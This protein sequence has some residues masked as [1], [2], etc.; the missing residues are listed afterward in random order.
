MANNQIKIGV[1]FQIDKTGLNELQNSLK[2]I[3][4]TASN[5]TSNDK[6]T[7][8]LREAASAAKVVDTALE[9]AFNKN[10]G[11]TN[12]S[13]FN[14][15]LKK[16]NLTIDQVRIKFAE[17]GQAG[18]KAWN[19]L[20]SQIL[21]TNTQLKQSNKLLDE[22]ATSM[23]NTV[24][25]G[26]TSSIF[27]TIT[28][29]ISKAYTYTK[30]LD[31][32]LN[33]IRIVTDK[34]AESMEKFA[35]QANEAA[36]GLGAS[37]LDYTEA[38]LIYY[39]QGLDDAQVAARAETTLKAANVT[40]QY[41]EEVSEQLTAVWNGYKVSAEEA[42]LYVDKLAAVAA[43]TAADLEELSTGMS[44]VASAANS[45]G[46]DIDQLNAQLATI[47]S[48]TRQ[49]PESVGTALKT[50]YARMSDLKVGGTDE[51]G[52]GLGD[53]SG[54]MESMGIQVL[55]ASGN[56][57]EMGDV[58]EEVAAK[59]DTWT[60]A[61]KT[62]MAQVMAGKRQYNNLVALFD[63]WDMYTDSLNES[64]NAAGTLQKQQ[65]IYLE[66]T[67]AKL[68]Q[69]RTTAESVY[70]GLIKTDELNTGIE[71]LTDF[72]QVASN[73]VNSFGGGIKSISSL[74]L[75]VANIFNKQ[76]ANGI[77]NVI[78]GHK[79]AVDNAEMYRIKAEQLQKI[80]KNVVNIDTMEGVKS[81]AIAEGYQKQAEYAQK[82]QDIQ[83]NLS[84]EEY[85]R[86]NTLTAEV[87]ELTEQ[88]TLL[89]KASVYAADQA[90]LNISDDKMKAVFEGKANF[91]EE[92]TKRN[93]EIEDYTNQ[94]NQ[95]KN[96]EKIYN[97]IVEKKQI[98]TKEDIKN[99]NLIEQEK[100][101]IEVILK[102]NNKKEV[103]MKQ[104]AKVLKGILQSNKQEIEDHE[105]II[106]R[107]KTE[108]DIYKKIEQ[109]AASAQR[110]EAEKG[111]KES[112]LNEGLG[113]G[114]QSANVLKGVTQV[115][116]ALSTMA[117]SW[118]S[119]NSLMDTWED[120][121]LSVG[122]KLSQTLMTVGMTLP[123]LISS[124]KSLSEVMGVQTTLMEVI[125]ALHMKSNVLKTTGLVLNKQ[126]LASLTAEVVIT[127][128]AAFA[129]ALKN[130]NDRAAVK[131]LT[132][133]S[134]AILS[135]IGLT[136]QEKIAVMQAKVA[137]DAWNS[138]LLANP[139][140]KVIAALAGLVAIIG[141]VISANE[142]HIE[143]QNELAKQSI[144]EQNKIQSEI[145]ANTELYNSY[146]KTF[147]AYKQ[148]KATK[149]E[150]KTVTDQLCEK[151]NLERAI[152]ANLTGDYQ[153]LT[154]EIIKTQKVKIQEGLKSA[155]NEKANAESLVKGQIG[156]DKRVQMSAGIQITGADVQARKIMEK[157]YTDNYG[158]GFN[159]NDI[160]SVVIA[161]DAL[162]NAMTEI[163]NEMDVAQRNDSDII[164]DAQ[165][166]LDSMTESVEAYKTA[167]QDVQTYSAQLKSL[168]IDFYN[169]DNLEEY[170]EKRKQLIE[171]M[172]AD[173]SFEGKS[174][175]ELEAM[176]DTFISQQNDSLGLYS[177]QTKQ[178]A[179]MVEQYGSAYENEIT[180]WIQSLPEEQLGI[181][182]SLEL[183]ELDYEEVQT[184][185]QE[186]YAIGE[187]NTIQVKIDT[188]T[189]LQDKINKGE[190]LTEEERTAAE[191]KLGDLINWEEFDASTSLEQINLLGEALNELNKQRIDN[192]NN[193]KEAED[194]NKKNEEERI[195][196]IN[197]IT[198]DLE[199]LDKTTPT[200]SN[201]KHEIE[202]TKKELLNELKELENL[203]YSIDLD[204]NFDNTVLDIIGDKV[205]NIVSK[206]DQLKN[207]S[208]L[209]GEGF[210]VAAKD[211]ETL[212][213]QFPALMQNADVL[214]NG[215]VKLQEEIVKT[216]LNG[217]AA[218]LE[219][220]KNITDQQLE[221]QIVLL[222]AEIESNNSKIKLMT[223]YLTGKIESNKLEEGLEKEQA[224]LESK[225]INALGEEEYKSTIQAA[226]NNTE[227]TNN[228]LGNLDKIGTRA[229]AVGEAI[230]AA[231]AGE[232][233]NYT[234]GG[235]TAVTTTLTAFQSQN[236]VE[237]TTRTAKNDK[238]SAYIQEVE[239]QREEL[240]K[241]NEEKEKLIASY[242]NLQSELRSGVT[243]A[244][245][246]MKGAAS[247]TGGKANAD[248]KEQKKAQDEI[249]RYWELNKAIEEVEESLSDLD[250]KQEKLYGKELIASLKQENQ[251]LAQQADRYQALAA[252][253]RQEA[254]E[255][256]GLLSSYGVVFDAQGGI[257]NYLAAT[258]AALEAY[259]QTVAAYN[260]MLIDEA[261]FKA[262]ERAYENFKSTLARYET[263]YYQE[264]VD[265]QNKL[266]EIHRQELE[267]NL[268]AWEVEIQLKLDMNELE[269]Q[270]DDFFKDI[271]NNFKLLYEDLDAEMSNLMDKTLTYQGGDGDIATIISGI[272][273][274][275]AEIDKMQSGGESGMFESVSQAQEKLKELNDQL[276]DSALAMRE[277][278]ETAWDTYLEGIDQAADK[279]DDLMDRYD[280]INEEIEYQRELIELL[281]GD[282]AYELMNQYYDAQE[283]NTK[284]EIDSL[285]IQA[286]LWKAQYE[287][288]LAIDEANGTLSEDTQKFYELWQDAQQGLNDKVTEYIELL[289]NDYKNTI[290]DIISDLEKSITGG[291]A[292][293]EVKEQWELLK[294]QSE[295]YY[296][297]VERI[298]ELSSLASKYENSI[299]NT[300]NL[301]NQQK[302]Q[303]MYNKEMKYLENKKFLSEY[304]L[305][306]ANAKYD[307]T[308]KQ[309]ML[310]EAQQNKTSMKLTRGSDG[311]WSYQYVA[312]ED[313][314]ASKQQALLDA[315]SQYYQIT[316]D[317]YHQNLEDM[318]SA[319]ANYL[320]KLQE[321]N[322]KYMN[323]EEMRAAKAQEL[324]EI[325]YGENGILTLLYMQ[326]EEARTN[327]ADSTLQSILTFYAIDEENYALMTESEQALIDGLKDGTIT[328]YEEMLDKATQ[329]CEDT[330]SSWESSAQG[331][332]DAWYVD[333]GYSVKASMLQ[334][335]KDLTKANTDYQT[336]VDILE[337]S[338]EQD[339]GPD[340]IGG[341]LDSAKNK[342]E[343]LDNKTAELCNHAESNLTRYRE[344]VNQIGYA[345][346]SVKDQIRSAISLVQQYL[347]AVGAAQSAAM[348]GLASVGGIG[349]SSGTGGSGSGGGSKNSNEKYYY[350]QT[351]SGTDG[352][353]FSVYNSAG[354]SVSGGLSKDLDWIQKNYPNATLK[355]NLYKNGTAFNTGGYTGEWNNGDMNGRLAW[356]H[357]KELVLNSSDT[358]NILD[359][360][361]T[362]RG[363]TNIGE[364]INESIM[365]GISQMVLSLM[366]LGNYGK[367]YNLATAEGGQE[368][369]F[370]INANF[371]NANDVESIR[372]AIM[373]LPNLASQYIARNRK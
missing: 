123:M 82:I 197:E 58:I 144:D 46:V 111:S 85:N 35:K 293:D 32:S 208:E 303:E 100:Q 162:S 224:E 164:K 369:V 299:I 222:E 348:S 245:K 194:E 133:E 268:K 3:Q 218:I 90:H 86:L 76:L 193:L 107:L 254:S 118:M 102:S 244:T 302:L 83:H 151:Y 217:N 352:A 288:A 304:D 188:V 92:I 4:I 279:L 263:L 226:I 354:Q 335:Y 186:L 7:Q 12:L 295:K 109:D 341:A 192:Y 29:S 251:L 256:Q 132:A 59:W 128:K 212:S 280:S 157:Y 182:M 301:E 331:I 372:E 141:A 142:K 41:A 264:M 36:K 272:K 168:N 336:A 65:E 214:A 93:D 119:I 137:Q 274:V 71:L 346:E 364:S 34:S 49:A 296:D 190:A 18:S 167:V 271:N 140:I 178:I 47:V 156:N 101:K 138:S 77:N 184:K 88:I 243:D 255:L 122:Q 247:G 344:A 121:S 370:N 366:N 54:T 227:L 298:Y 250:K 275:T 176:A 146:M 365:N 50:I 230:R 198:R 314:I 223:D 116:S 309:I 97:N 241:A 20:G 62:A 265:T 22:M 210:I 312:D 94:I 330:L 357:Q 213:K 14:Q 329:V 199:A 305:Q 98:I 160:D 87:G 290:S 371:P 206:A 327:M 79:K 286:D 201:E 161:Y 124:F 216:V 43:S 233:V 228:V 367:G 285:K 177:T 203:N 205:D 235:N 187:R 229:Q 209:I 355:G 195:K 113:I 277:L 332:A 55:D 237:Q 316:K 135:K 172:K 17:A 16:N 56:L 185:V 181:L 99:L 308:L 278:W 78:I 307:M 154:E 120:K 196:R 170:K 282:E 126:E 324:Y 240:L 211:V 350:V 311:N 261:T 75:I 108:L 191:T 323:D 175:E 310:E 225:L 130:H 234:P 24:K 220:N 338:V 173:T 333:N 337:K 322:E 6:M 183:N 112:D 276:Q 134:S 91:E 131:C 342:T 53:V 40:G 51:D 67:N 351:G 283:K 150:M 259:N 70:S 202:Q 69:L 104:V 106:Q 326:N 239:R 320:E 318:M 1:G 139:Y 152:V 148:G 31:G 5:A 136:R 306:V 45:M 30:K 204:V 37:T 42:E 73:F 153:K 115:T 339:F 287:E 66:S 300:S 292:L 39:Q 23:A 269:R 180:N 291:A 74:L 147:D 110:L 273:D 249:D 28:N 72:T 238:E 360:V 289:Q 319:Q 248:K 105:Q 317:G 25:W 361:H 52:L 315:T 257:A 129:Q 2:Q 48:V 169:I 44:K 19:L 57:R 114:Q 179:K 221:D 149:E 267:N 343:E 117:M 253:Q 81:A 9:K 242:K 262:A 13:K 15:E 215:S 231:M 155:T 334:A 64:A 95:A 189:N 145:D 171:N 281:Y 368:S 84:Q 33:D 200:N 61:Q 80:S 328:N 270:W 166:W 174:E 358:A 26:I 68:Q 252:A 363:I 143:Q 103:K 356:L 163:N 297:D 266:E 246:S 89:E 362:V 353:K 325:Y 63:N 27:N 207:V 321:I 21:K 232:V 8:S 345:W 10:L 294:E 127:D 347:N 60:D 38:S 159:P 219:S 165:S 373:S 258:Q 158:F 313:D 11:T 359:A 96:L 260:A 236:I 349:S 125:N 340:G 284:A